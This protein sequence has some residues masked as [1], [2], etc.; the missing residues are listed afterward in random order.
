MAES[1]PLG[2]ELNRIVMER[3][4]AAESL[5]RASAPFEERSEAWAS[6]SIVEEQ[7]AMFMTDSREA[8]FARRG[9]I[10]AAEKSGDAERAT[11][12]REAFDI[13]DVF[14]PPRR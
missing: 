2:D 4:I 9:A 13:W 6:V 1:I 8:A 10:M 12:L 7:I 11:H 14:G 5:D 3:I